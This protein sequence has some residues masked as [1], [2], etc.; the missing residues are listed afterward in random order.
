[1]IS[2]VKHVDTVHTAANLLFIMRKLYKD[3]YWPCQCT[4]S[5]AS[6]D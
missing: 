3:I 2:S 5:S 1:M 6:A 4:L